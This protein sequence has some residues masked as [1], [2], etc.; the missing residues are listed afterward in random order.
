MLL[1]II[2]KPNNDVRLT[3]VSDATECIYVPIQDCNSIDNVNQ[4][5]MIGLFTY[6]NFLLQDTPLLDGKIAVVT[7]HKLLT[8]IQIT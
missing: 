3:T 8:C 7:V 6:R 4:T 1:L 5:N 2:T